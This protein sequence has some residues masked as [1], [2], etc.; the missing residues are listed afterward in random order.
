[1][2]AYRPA[3]V[4]SNAEI[5][6]RA[7]IAPDW[8]ASRSG[9]LNRRHARPDESLAMMAAA[10]GGAALADAGVDAAEVDLV[11]V[12]TTTQRRPIPG[13]APE[14]AYLMGAARAG[15][16]D[17]NGACAG[18][19]YALETAASAVRSGAASTVVVAGA[20]RLTDWTGPAV[21]DTFALLADGAGAVVV[22]GVEREGIGPCVWGSDG[23]KRSIIEIPDGAAEMTMRGPLVYKW[24]VEILPSVADEVCKLAGVT[25]DDLAWLVLHQANRRILTTVAKAVGVPEERVLFDLT[26]SGNTS[27]ASI[28]LALSEL[29]RRGGGRDGRPLLLLGFGA[30]LTYAGQVVW[31]R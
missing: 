27:S 1:V 19:C 18:F 17:L 8:I 7:A 9:I 11:I 23:A 25:F 20:E 28:P 26:D 22:A 5:A 30:G 10:A 4:V 2:G 15:A 3:T 6:Q 31:L 12:A 14:A 16:F 24:A 29:R 13:V 21:P